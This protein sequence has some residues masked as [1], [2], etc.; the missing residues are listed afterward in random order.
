MRGR[1]LVGVTAAVFAAFAPAPAVATST[2][3][4]TVAGEVYLDLD[5]DGARDPGE[6][7]IGDVQ[8]T[9]RTEATIL[10]ATVSDT[11]GSWAFNNV[12]LGTVTLVVEPPNGLRVT[13][14]T[15]DG[16]DTA[17]SEAEVAVTEDVELGAVGLGSPVLSGPDVATAIAV[18]R[19]ASTADEYR[20]ELTAFNLGPDGAD[21]PVDLRAVLSGG[22][23]VVAAS[24]T[25]WSC[26]T[27]IAIV[28]CSISSDLAA[29]T[30]L[31]TV[32]LTTTPVEDVGTTVTVTGTVRLE[33]VVDDAPLNDEAVASRTIGTELAAED[34]DGDGAGDLTT[35][36]AH[37]RGLL[38]AALLVLV[39]GATAVTTTHR[40]RRP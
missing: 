8:L 33:G 30:A 39:V 29:G 32:A 21:G 19:A 22:H 11:D 38:V 7:G 16:F 3:G 1:A 17:R 10:D 12:P 20:W 27:S 4:A 23:E 24:G 5:A 36:G 18:D 14:S 2:D 26:E 28:L 35:A 9:L 37:V 25:G 15:V 6:P 31:S 13:G 40:T 34:L